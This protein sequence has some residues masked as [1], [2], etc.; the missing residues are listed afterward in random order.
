MTSG[1]RELRGLCRDDLSSRVVE[2]S[3]SRGRIMILV[4]FGSKSLRTELLVLIHPPRECHY[5]A[6]RQGPTSDI[7]MGWEVGKKCP[8]GCDKV[9]MSEHN[10]KTCHWVIR[11]K[12]CLR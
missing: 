5:T 4:P 11:K 7:P 6:H 1:I 3:Q 8:F 10:W 9:V 2:Q 12:R